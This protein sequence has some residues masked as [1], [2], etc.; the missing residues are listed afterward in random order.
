[1]AVLDSPWKANFAALEPYW[2]QVHSILGDTGI[3]LPLIGPGDDGA[4]NASSFKTRRRTSSGLEAVFTW[5]ASDAGPSN[6]TNGNDYTNPTSRWQGVVPFVN[7]DGVD[8]EADTPDA[9]YWTRALAVA[10]WGAWVNMVDATDS[11][12]LGRWTS[13]GDLREWLFWLNASDQAQI[14]LYDESEASNPFIRTVS[15][16]AV[17]EGAW[18][19]IVATYDG[20]ADASGL[21]IYYDGVLV[22]STDT[23]QAGFVSTEDL[24]GTTTLGMY[25]AGG[26]GFFDGAMAG[27]P[28]GP[29]F[30]QKELT[31]AEIKRL[32]NLGRAALG[33]T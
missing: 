10:S 4:P 7:F 27:G 24:G 18:Q 16:V 6:W 15:D 14:S 20:S 31:A 12:I 21:N 29:F 26:S 22:A 2:E 23:D 19:F 17:K 25:N 11:N 5:Q 28:F 33:L 8:D 1:M 32:Y 30:T 13:S 9:A 3:V